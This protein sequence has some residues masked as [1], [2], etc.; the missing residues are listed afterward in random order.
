MFIYHQFQADSRLIIPRDQKRYS[1]QPVVTEFI[2]A[3]LIYFSLPTDFFF[4]FTARCCFSPRKDCAPT[5]FNLCSMA[6]GF[7]QFLKAA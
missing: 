3:V 6:E 7:L 2:A 5:V 4:F 1:N